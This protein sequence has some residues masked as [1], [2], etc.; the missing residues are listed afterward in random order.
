[1][2]HTTGARVARRH[3]PA[4]TAEA[5]LSES[6]VCESCGSIFKKG[7]PQSIFFKATKRCLSRDART[8]DQRYA[9]ARKPKT[10]KRP[11]FKGHKKLPTRRKRADHTGLY[12]AGLLT[13][14][15]LSAAAP[16]AAKQILRT[17]QKLQI[18]HEPGK[19]QGVYLKPGFSIAKGDLLLVFSG[20][21]S[22]QRDLHE[23]ADRWAKRM[24]SAMHVARDGSEVT[25]AQ[26]HSVYR[27]FRLSYACPLTLAGEV[28]VDPFADA[29][30]FRADSGFDTAPQDCGSRTTHLA[31]L[32]NHSAH[33]NAKINRSCKLMPLLAGVLGERVRVPCVTAT[34]SIDNRSGAT[35]VEITISYGYKNAAA[36]CKASPPPWVPYAIDPSEVLKRGGDM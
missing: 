22:M 6:H 32:C 16:D 29:M 25:P 2:K 17:Q 7:A 13:F 14:K 34:C 12:D 27:D 19:G 3:P 1:M 31:G 36:V 20:G 23:L 9:V 30:R 28:L 18:L 15:G 5:R 24:S 4:A 10:K 35:P 33:P 21:L 26:V 11:T 8:C